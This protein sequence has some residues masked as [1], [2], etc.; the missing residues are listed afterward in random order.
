MKERE[1]EGA[2]ERRYERTKVRGDEG[3]SGQATLLLCACNELLYTC[4][5]RYK[6]FRY[7]N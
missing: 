7:R 2:R 4:V 5:Q 1:N 3:Q 6:L